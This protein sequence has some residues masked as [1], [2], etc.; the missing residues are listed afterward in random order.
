MH[1]SGKLRSLERTTRAEP[2][3]SAKMV[4]HLGCASFVSALWRPGICLQVSP[5]LYSISVKLG[6]PFTHGHVSAKPQVCPSTEGDCG[7]RTSLEKGRNVSMSHPSFPDAAR[8]IPVGSRCSATSKMDRLGTIRV[9]KAAG[10]Q[11]K[12]L[13]QEPHYLSTHWQQ[14]P[15][16]LCAPGGSLQLASTCPS[17][18]PLYDQFPVYPH[19]LF[20]NT[21][22]QPWSAFLN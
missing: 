12:V 21:S 8:V 1:S 13:C 22:L 5:A 11:L 4:L 3:D 2:V 10:A 20:L 16:G 6:Q 14:A 19:C 17:P 7:K 18:P 15:A 9:R